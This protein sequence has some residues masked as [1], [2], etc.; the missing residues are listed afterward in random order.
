MILIMF[1]LTLNK[2]DVFLPRKS[3]NK[4][5]TLLPRFCLPLRRWKLLIEKIYVS[6][7]RHK[8][9]NFHD[10]YGNFFI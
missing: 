9:R 2:P 3:L 5:V 6:K 10:T 8:D 7:I 4:K 1:F